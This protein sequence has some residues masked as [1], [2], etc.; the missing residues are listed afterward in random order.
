MKIS[1]LFLLVGVFLF[2]Y[3][4]LNIDIGKTFQILLNANILLIIIVVFVVFLSVLIKAL[5][6]NILIH[7][8]DKEYPLKSATKAWLM[9]FSLSMV[10]PARIGDISRAY[11]IKHKV[12]V[13]KGITTVIIDRV[14]DI[15]ILFCMAIIGLVSFAAFFTADS[16][17]FLVVS[18]LFVMFVFGVYASTKKRLV[19]MLLKPIFNRIVP[20]KH[21]SSLNLTFHDF[22]AG[23]GSIKTYRK[24]IF[25][26]I[27]LGVLVWFVTILQYYLLGLA[28]GI[29]LPF[30]FLLSVAPIVALLDTLPIS[31]SGIGTRDAALILFLSFL[32]IGREYAISLSLLLFTLGYVLIGL[33]GSAFMLKEHIK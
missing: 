21:K 4:L 23:L 19:K 22:Y 2:I 1:R 26:P 17:L 16:S 25:I 32:S 8:Y 10:T 11:Y 24:N 5:K 6:W 13:G 28:I 18:V 3:I 9:G 27:A 33:V 7:I 15:T 12:S 31:F 14:I 30:M 20:E 29:N